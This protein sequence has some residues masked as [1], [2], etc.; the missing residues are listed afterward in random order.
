[1][2]LNTEQ[3]FSTAPRADI[4]RS[5]FDRSFTYKTTVGV[6]KLYPIFI[7]EALPGDT[8]YLDFTVFGR[9]IDPLVVPVADELY[10]E[11]LWFKC[12]NRLLWSNWVK[13]CGEQDNPTDSTDYIVPV[14]N[15][16]VSGFASNSLADYFGIP[17]LVPNLTKVIY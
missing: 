10:L 13:F 5:K 16:G 8:L 15:S 2:N 1:M 14:I 4:Q 6:N 11:T 12:P 3:Y 9:L 17:T 7:D